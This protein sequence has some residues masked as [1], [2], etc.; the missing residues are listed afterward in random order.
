MDQ[1]KTRIARRPRTYGC[2]EL[3]T[4]CRTLVLTR[5][6]RQADSAIAP[7]MGTNDGSTSSPREPGGEAAREPGERVARGSDGEADR[8]P[9]GATAQGQG[10]LVARAPGATLIEVFPEIALIV[11]ES[12]SAL[13]DEVASDLV[14]LPFGVDHVELDKVLGTAGVL[15]Q[16]ASAALAVG[17]L[18]G[19]VRLTPDTVAAMNGGLK[20]LVSGGGNLG[21]LTDAGG[22]FARQ[23]RW[24]P[25][26]PQV[27]GGT[28][29]A[30][31]GPAF[32]MVALQ[33]QLSRLEKTAKETR[34]IARKILKGINEDRQDELAGIARVVD[35]A[36][37]EAKRIRR[38]T[39]GVWEEVQGQQAKINDYREKYRRF[40]EGHVNEAR[41]LRG[42]SAGEVWAHV[43]ENGPQI[44]IDLE[45]YMTVERINCVYRALR[46]ARLRDEGRDDPKEAELSEFVA[47]DA[48]E[49]YE[50]AIGMMTGLVDA[51]NRGFHLA[52]AIEKGLL[53][54]TVVR[55]INDVVKGLFAGERKKTRE[56]GDGVQN[57]I[58]K[59][60]EG[61]G[62]FAAVI[63]LAS[64]RDPEPHARV[65]GK[66]TDEE[67]KELLEVLRW[68][69]ERDEELVG[70]AHATD[71]RQQ[72]VIAITDQ[73]VVEAKLADL[74]SR[75][76]FWREIPNDEI[77]YVRR[78]G[79]N[80]GRAELDVITKEE[81][82]T[83]SFGPA[84]ES[85]QAGLDAIT[86]MLAERMR[87]PEE[88]VRELTG[89]RSDGAPRIEAPAP[90]PLPEG[91]HSGQSDS[92]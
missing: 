51:L 91:G 61:V 53:D 77:R 63:G 36:F 32:M 6:L 42:S 14:E 46:A 62:R 50:N 85:D 52:A 60:A 86:G 57:A 80:E 8:E 11:G 40:V 29:L 64:P 72:A 79:G 25:V 27:A 66:R 4:R 3:H 45:C 18:Q 17:N 48:R 73:R 47:A 44:L 33:L 1:Q 75:G 38:V 31:L 88:E 28:V 54:K 12:L 24:K 5:Y 74:R 84:D 41:A 71:A 59:L 34:G 22:R 68:T 83:W 21:V 55:G 65:M 16:T 78:R 23:V 37:E 10:E 81:N 58:Q 76:E 30:S 13:P 2:E 39:P 87:L 7:L 89:S 9:D 69:L 70:F 56:P 15:A 35:Q 92:K 20:P 26:G 49:D 19:L 82:L 90:P 67:A 43:M